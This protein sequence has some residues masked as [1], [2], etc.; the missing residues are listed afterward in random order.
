MILWW[1]VVIAT[2]CGVALYTAFVLATR[3]VIK[4]GASSAHKRHEI[5][6]K[7]EDK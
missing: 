1:N 6:M 5:L 7:S 2:I 4:N 3:Y